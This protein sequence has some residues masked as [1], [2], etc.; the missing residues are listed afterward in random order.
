MTPAEAQAELLQL[1]DDATR[2]RMRSDA[3]FG[4]FL[5]GGLDSSSVVGFM[6]LYK[7]S[8]LQTFSVGFDDPRFDESA[9]ALAAAR[10]FGTLHERH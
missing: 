8:G 6:S 3:P 7:P 10:R 2:I 9:H 4:A 5:S 1:L